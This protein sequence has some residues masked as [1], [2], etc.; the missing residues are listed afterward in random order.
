MSRFSREWM[1]KGA[2]AKI[3]I[4]GVKVPGAI[5]ETKERMP[6]E[7]WYRIKIADDIMVWRKE[8]DVFLVGMSYLHNLEYH[9][10]EYM[11]EVQDNL[12]DI[13][14]EIERVKKDLVEDE[15]KES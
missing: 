4:N 7:F 10:R 3:L 11:R 2:E 6:G 9:K 15:G 8:A 14:A 1:I 12:N 5:F 13:N